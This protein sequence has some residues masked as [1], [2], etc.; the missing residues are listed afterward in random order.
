MKKKPEER[1]TE[2]HPYL[3]YSWTNKKIR[4]EKKKSIYTWPSHISKLLFN[5]KEKISVYFPCITIRCDDLL[6][7]LTFPLFQNPLPEFKKKFKK[8]S[9]IIEGLIL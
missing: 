6:E 7:K 3:M 5:K 1:V 8:N 4:K 9:K 2:S